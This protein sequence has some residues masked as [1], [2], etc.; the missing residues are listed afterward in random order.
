MSPSSL[1]LHCCSSPP[2]VGAIG[3]DGAVSRARGDRPSSARPAS[4]AL[5]SQ[6]VSQSVISRSYPAL[7]PPPA[8]SPAPPLPF[9]HKYRV[10][11]RN[12]VLAPPGARGRYSMSIDCGASRS[13]VILSQRTGCSLSLFALYC[14]G[15]IVLGKQVGVGGGVLGSSRSIRFIRLH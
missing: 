12:R 1:V 13:E 10:L 14:W 11:T 4:G 8:L 3:F 6:S 2:T 9:N 15:G 5:L 7:T